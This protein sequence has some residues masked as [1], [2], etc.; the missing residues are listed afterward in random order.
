MGLA[1]NQISTTANSNA[2]LK[3][4]WRMSKRANDL[5]LSWKYVEDLAEESIGVNEIEMQ[6]WN[7]TMNREVK[8]GM[9]RPA[10]EKG[11][12][13]KELQR[14][15]NLIKKQMKLRAEQAKEDWMTVRSQFMNLKKTLME[16]TMNEQERNLIKNE[17][18]KM[19]RRNEKSFILVRE[20]HKE[21]IRKLREKLKN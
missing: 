17:V 5:A 18:K 1:N 19:K 4:L 11:K 21:K 13:G 2:G 6:V 8:K 14:N 3:G 10:L 7:R 16:R 20:N 12:Y 15:K 9:K